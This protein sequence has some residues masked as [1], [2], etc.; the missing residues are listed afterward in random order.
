MATS[1]IT[2]EILS[3]KVQRPKSL[4]ED[5][6]FKLV[7]KIESDYQ[8]ELNND[9]RER[10]AR[11]LGLSSSSSYRAKKYHDDPCLFARE[12][13]GRTLTQDQARV[14]T[15]LTT[16]DRVAVASGHKIGKSTLASVAALWFYATRDQ[17]RVIM[18]SVTS[19]QVDQILWREIQILIRQAEIPIDGE[20][21]KM[22]R[23]GLKS[24]DFREIVGFTAREAEAVAG[25]SGKNLMYILDEASGIGDDIYTAVEGNR[26]GGAK[27]LMCSNP[28]RTEGFFFDS[29]FKYNKTEDRPEGVFTMQLSSETSPNVKEGRIVIPGLATRD[30]VEEKRREWGEDSA[31]YKVR[32]LGQ[33]VLREEGKIVSLHTI[34]LAEQ[35]WAETPAEGVLTIGLDP[36][37]EGGD[38]DETI[39]AIRRGLKILDFMAFRG[40]TAEAH[41]SQLLTVIRLLQ[42][43]DEIPR[44]ILD[45][46]GAV[47][48]TVYGAF[49]AYL[50][51]FPDRDRPFL[52]HPVRAAQRATREPDVWDRQRDAL[53]GNMARW[54]RSAEEGGEGGAIPEDARLAAELHCPEWYTSHNGR[55]KVTPKE[56]MRQFLSRSPDRADALCLA[57]WEPSAWEQEMDDDSRPSPPRRLDPFSGAISP[58]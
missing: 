31:L 58:W 57:V 9:A 49:R 48:A 53:W 12:V 2:A 22:A 23:T 54:M 11:V 37:G 30:W 19:R 1:T 34:E 29:F 40:L 16:H 45:R 21:H 42:R 7:A 47:G 14:L 26:A 17:A 25:I 35:R 28:T 15:A 10:L 3:R 8:K 20:L 38:G 56:K 51:R 52:L 24:H 55:Q 50:E 5:I 18:S 39:F 4:S 33:F 13:L 43:P 46:E 6:A 27:V 44:V 41:V 32:V 36:A